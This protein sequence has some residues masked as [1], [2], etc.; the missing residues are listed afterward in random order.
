[1]APIPI[2]VISGEEE[3]SNLAVLQGPLLYRKAHGLTPG[4][5]VQWI[6]NVLD[7]QRSGERRV[8]PD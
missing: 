2:I 5:V 1:M 8:R 6:Q 4:E 7:S 3:I